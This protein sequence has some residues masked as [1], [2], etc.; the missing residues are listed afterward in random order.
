MQLSKTIL[1]DSGAFGVWRS[2][3]EIDLVTYTEFCLEQREA[4]FEVV[5]LDRIPGSFGTRPTPLQVEES[6]KLS[7]A[8]TTFMR[9]QG[10]QPIP[11]YHYREDIRWLD[12]MVDE[13][14]D[15]IGLSS[16]KRMPGPAREQWPGTC[17]AHLCGSSP[18]PSVRLHGFGDAS[19]TMLRKYPWFS[20]DSLSYVVTASN[21]SV[22]VPRPLDGEPGTA[23]F[24][25]TP[26]TVYVSAG[27]EAGKT[28]RAATT[29]GNDFR[30]FGAR[31]R[32]HVLRWC[33]QLGVRFEALAEHHVPRTL[34][35]ALFL[36][37]YVAAYQ[38]P[39]LKSKGGFFRGSGSAPADRWQF[40]S[41]LNFFLVAGMSNMRM[42]NA[43]EGTNHEL[44]TYADFYKRKK[45]WC[46][47][48]YQQDPI[49]VGQA[50][51]VMKFWAAAQL[52]PG[53]SN[54]DKQTQHG[55]RSRKAARR[56]QAG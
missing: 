34:S 36:Q 29:Q 22:W 46:F 48:E 20:V 18:Y 47:Y 2:G 44:F 26:A 35:N 24:S 56:R 31:D 3:A 27:G 43:I 15:Y 50:E 55:T 42:T 39:Q 51:S 45:P 53:Q 13:G 33:D 52:K 9:K 28:A 54:L 7:H 8:N 23:D 30:T 25:R 17:F 40:G 21:G 41:A 1:L 38:R 49:A 16:D 5:A 14:Y 10:L 4:L 19:F 12:R 37:R 6:A 11:V 32:E